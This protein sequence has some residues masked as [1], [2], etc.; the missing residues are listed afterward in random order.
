MNLTN[1]ERRNWEENSFSSIYIPNNE[2]IMKDF[3]LK[4]L[5][6]IWIESSASFMPFEFNL[7]DVMLPLGINF[8]DEIP[9]NFCKRKRDD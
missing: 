6:G 8:G 3:S 4:I 9:T 5:C 7:F 1:V 2:K